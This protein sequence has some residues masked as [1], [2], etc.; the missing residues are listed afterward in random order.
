MCSAHACTVACVADEAA[1]AQSAVPMLEPPVIHFIGPH[2]GASGRAV[3]LVWK[4]GW[5]SDGSAD[6]A[7]GAPPSPR[8]PS[9]LPPA[10]LPK[11]VSLP[12]LAVQAH[13]S[14]STDRE[15][16]CSVQLLP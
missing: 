6:D 4:V 16:L 2:R 1:M 14:H 10:S 13:A 5:P 15:R 11:L 9:P 3:L 7:L 8:P 12:L